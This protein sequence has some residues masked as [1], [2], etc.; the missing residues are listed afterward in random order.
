MA[1][2]WRPAWWPTSV[3]FDEVPAAVVLPEPLA[4]EVRELLASGE[5]TEA[6][7]RVRQRTHL[8]LLPAAL[9]VD[10]MHDG[11]HPSR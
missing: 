1:S 7:R 6:V 2:R 11:A 8:G 9:A 3:R 5:R 4:S 10:A